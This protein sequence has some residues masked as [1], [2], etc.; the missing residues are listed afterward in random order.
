ML[1]NAAHAIDTH[2]EITVRSWNAKGWIFVSFNDTGRG[3]PEHQLPRIFEPFFTT[4]EAGSGT[5]L[6]LSSN[7]EIVRNHGGEIRVV[8]EIG[9]GSTFTVSIPL[10]R[11]PATFIQAII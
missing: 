10:E 1:F 5:G 9:Q 7:N 11:V 4:K 3:I 6:G 8:S 2:G